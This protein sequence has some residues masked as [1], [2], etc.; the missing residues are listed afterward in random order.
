[1]KAV[2][3]SI[4]LIM[5]IIIMILGGL[6]WFDYLGIVQAKRLF[7]PLYHLMGRDPQTSKSVSSAVAVIG[8][9]DQERLDK[10]REALDLYK[11]ALEK[12]KAELELAK[13]QNEATA[14]VLIND[15]KSF[16]EDQKTFALRVSQYDEKDKNV[17]QI[18]TNLNGMTP[19]AAV[20]IL[21]DMDDQLVIDVLRKVEE[22]ARTS[23]TSSMGGYWLSL[24]PSDRAATIQRKM[25]SKAESLD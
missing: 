1:M 6:L 22:I 23:G 17:T 19:Q 18:A 14:A 12:E 5:L 2:G 8:D 16:E 3:K 21:V 7:T 20:A 15:R 10:T 4:V 25:L 11:Q 24:M 13:A 9:L